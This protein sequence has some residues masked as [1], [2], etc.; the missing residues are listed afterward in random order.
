MSMFSSYEEGEASDFCPRKL[1]AGFVMDFFGTSIPLRTGARGA[2]RRQCD[3]TA[4]KSHFPL[5]V[6]AL[7][8]QD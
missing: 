7:C 2:M 1:D 5:I 3:H 6:R 4:R 8:V